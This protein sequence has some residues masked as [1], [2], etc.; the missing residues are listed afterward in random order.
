MKLKIKLVYALLWLVVIGAGNIVYQMFSPVTDSCPICEGHYISDNLAFVDTKTGYIYELDVWIHDRARI[1]EVGTWED[2]LKGG[3]HSTFRQLGHNRGIYLTHM[4]GGEL[5][6]ELGNECATA[7]LC[8]DHKEYKGSY[9][10]VDTKEEPRKAYIV[11]DGAEYKIRHYTV[12]VS[13]E[14]GDYIVKVESSLFEEEVKE[15]REA[16]E[17]NG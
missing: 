13:L 12:N 9:V 5:R 7:Y 2:Q 11:E 8:K 3:D 14:E 16:R 6:Y 10:L 4:G 15:W 1:E 17:Q